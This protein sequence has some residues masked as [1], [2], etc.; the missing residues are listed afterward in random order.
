MSNSGQ[1]EKKTVKTPGLFR[2]GYRLYGEAV[3]TFWPVSKLT[4]TVPTASPV[5][6]SCT[7]E[8]ARAK[9]VKNLCA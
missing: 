3:V 5:Q 7:P 2:D 9:T 8:T 4:P 1:G 6:Q